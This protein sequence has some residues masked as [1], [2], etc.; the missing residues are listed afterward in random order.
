MATQKTIDANQVGKIGPRFFRCDVVQHFRLYESL[1]KHA[2]EQKSASNQ[3]ATERKPPPSGRVSR[4]SL[5]MPAILIA[6][7][8]ARS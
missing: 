3:E 2:A 5:T 1:V 6:L 8:G 4:F 7:R